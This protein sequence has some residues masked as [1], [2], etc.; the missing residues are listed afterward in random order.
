MLVR[1]QRADGQDAEPVEDA[2]VED[3]ARPGKQQDGRRVQDA[4]P[5]NAAFTPNRAGNEWRFW[6]RSTSMSKIA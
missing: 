3:E 2:G 4:R 5:Q 6:A 1:E